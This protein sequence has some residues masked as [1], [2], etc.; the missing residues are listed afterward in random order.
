MLYSMNNQP[1]GTQHS[2]N[3]QYRITRNNSVSNPNLNDRPSDY[4][5]EYEVSVPMLPTTYHHNP[6]H[7]LWN[8]HQW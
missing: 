7:S 3:N 2:T 4:H 1:T 8:L 5:V 6:Y